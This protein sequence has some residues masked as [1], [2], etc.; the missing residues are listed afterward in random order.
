MTFA[1]Q[2]KLLWNGSRVEE[3]LRTGRTSPV[4]V[5]IAPVG[6]C[7]ASCPWCFFKDK[8]SAEI[9]GSSS[10][11]RAIKDMASLGLK[12]I[13]WSGGGEP[14]LHPG[15]EGFVMYAKSLGLKQGLFTNGYQEIPEQEAFEW[16]RISLT[17]QGFDPI[18]K[19]RV[20]FGICL[21]DLAEYDDSDI[22]VLCNKA[23][24]FGASYFQ[25]RPA[26]IGSYNEQPEIAA[27][28]WLK[29]FETEDFKV[30]VTDYKYEESV[31]RK[32][33]QECFG[34]H[35]CPSIDWN[36]KVAVCLYLAQ[37]PDYILGDLK[38]ESI[39]DIWPRIPASAKV[40][41]KCQNCCKNHEINKLLAK[42]KTVT[43][44]SFL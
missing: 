6:Y 20:P 32:E 40:T 7:N 21:N 10:L 4:L 2:A 11:L 37:D 42:S 44:E 18:V 16:I 8:H 27:P 41:E 25:I 31:L 39:L 28:Y 9:I 30:I 1:P 26:L 34:F 13:N 15:F 5:E 19:P 35:F 3:W 29:G 12:A 14:V 38:T 22:E 33:Y 43:E 17:N 24:E 23:R 36:E